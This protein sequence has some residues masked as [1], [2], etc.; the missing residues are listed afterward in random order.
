MPKD[1]TTLKTF[2]GEGRIAMVVSPIMDSKGA[3][4]HMIRAFSLLKMSQESVKREVTQI[5]ESLSVFIKL[6]TKLR[7]EMEE[8][9]LQRKELGAKIGELEQKVDANEFLES[10]KEFQQ[11][12]LKGSADADSVLNNKDSKEAFNFVE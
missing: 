7:K 4:T 1:S 3:K 8:Q 10:V 9:Q 2:E 11:T 12:W 6:V 5:L